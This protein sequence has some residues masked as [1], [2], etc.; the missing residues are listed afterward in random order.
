MFQV[1]FI[2]ELLKA[3][4]LQTNNQAR[5]LQPKPQQ[6]SQQQA[7][8]QP[9]SLQ[10]KAQNNLQ[11]QQPQQQQATLQ[12]KTQSL[13]QKQQPQ[14]QQQQYIPPPPSLMIQS[15]APPPRPPPPKLT[16][17][18][19]KPIP[20]PP[21]PPP[22]AVRHYIQQQQ[23]QQQQ[24]YHQNSLQVYELPPIELP[25]V[26]QAIRPYRRKTQSIIGRPKE[27]YS[28]SIYKRRVK[29]SN[30]PSRTP[31]K[32]YSYIGSR[33]FSNS[34]IDIPEVRKPYTKSESS[35]MVRQEPVHEFT[36]SHKTRKPYTKSE[37][38]FMVRHERIRERTPPPRSRRKVRKVTVYV[39]RTRSG[40][41]SSSESA[42]TAEFITKAVVHR[43]RS[44][45]FDENNFSNDESLKADASKEEIG[46]RKP[47]IDNRLISPKDDEKRLEKEK[48]FFKPVSTYET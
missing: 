18:M 37:S 31:T 26:M 2:K 20:P 23:P 48:V 24:Y 28:S 44:Y 47:K 7:I 27:S 42:A 46:K 41:N 13:F 3:I 34:F 19:L 17:T 1:L 33:N 12:Q 32:S 40:S 29:L 15:Q 4:S 22:P 5:E 43:S 10:P 14:S 39:P 36:S 30:D 8:L 21:I 35:Y 9:A 25:P 11:K 45:Q 6:Q 16:S 38:S